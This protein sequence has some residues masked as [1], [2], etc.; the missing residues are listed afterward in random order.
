MW[1]R[2]TPL[3]ATRVFSD[4]SGV[5]T[6][7]NQVARRAWCHQWCQ[8]AGAT[9]SAAP[10]VGYS[11]PKPCRR[12]TAS[13]LLPAPL[14]LLSRRSAVAA[15]TAGVSAHVEADAAGAHVAL[16]KVLVAE[17]DAQP[18]PAKARPPPQAG[19]ALGRLAGAPQPT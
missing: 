6:D 13:Q 14:V 16:R 5:A 11:A 18:V 7:R 3:P 4:L 10:G 8:L 2:P 9:R 19:S 1:V 17:L 15:W 12:R